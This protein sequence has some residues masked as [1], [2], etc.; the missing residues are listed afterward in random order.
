MKIITLVALATLS[1][2]LSSCATASHDKLVLQSNAYKCHGN[3]VQ[4]AA[5]ERVYVGDRGTTAER[6]M[7]AELSAK[8]CPGSRS[9]TNRPVGTQ[10]ITAGS[11]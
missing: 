2:P 11:R 8:S 5:S 10:A 6:R 3:G 1:L 7:D 4:A 9:V